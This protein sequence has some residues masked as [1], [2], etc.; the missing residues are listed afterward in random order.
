MTHRRNPFRLNLLRQFT[1]LAAI[2]VEDFGDS[3]FYNSKIRNNGVPRY[4]RETLRHV[5]ARPADPSALDIA[6]DLDPDF[7]EQ[8][9]GG[10]P[11]AA[12]EA[13]ANNRAVQPAAATHST[14]FLTQTQSRET[15]LK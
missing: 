6:A 14:L 1:T 9:A 5:R 7:A 15:M 13:A 2:S 4:L 3:I 10:L 12:I 11:P 8:R